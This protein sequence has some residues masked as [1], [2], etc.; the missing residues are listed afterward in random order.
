[1]GITIELGFAYLDLPDG[2][3]AGI[4]DV[5]GHERFVRNMLAGA[6]SI[7]L[8]ILVVAADEGIM[9]QTRE[10]L[11][12]LGLL[13][14]RHGLVA[15][16]KA[17]L[18]DEDWLAMV[19]LDIEDEL[20]GTF[21]ANAPIMPVSAY[22]GS[23]IEELRRTIFAMLS[24]SPA[25]QTGIPFRL[26]IDRVFTMDGFGTVVTGT[27][28]E[29]TLAVGDD[30]AVFP[31][32]LTTR[33][34][35]I[36]VHDAQVEQAVAGQRVAVNLAGLKVSDIG[37][38]DWAAAPASMENS[39]LLDVVLEV[40]KDCPRE[41]K[42][43][44][45]LHLHHGTQDVLC[46][47]M[48]MDVDKLTAGQRAYG[49]LR[50]AQPL[51]AKPQD[52]FVLRFYSPTETIGGGVILDPAPRRAKRHD[53]EN[54]QRLVLKENG[55]LKERVQV[56]F[57]ENSV[58]FPAPADLQ[59][60]YFYGDADFDAVL[61]ELLEEGTLVA[62]GDG[63]LYI[64]FLKEL[65]RKAQETLD[66]Y[67]KTNPLHG[68]MAL[69]ELCGKLLPRWRQDAAEYAVE[70]LAKL[71]FVKQGGQTVAHA[72]FAMAATDAHN[73]IRDKVLATYTQAGFATPAFDDVAADFAK[74]KR[75]FGQVFEAL[76][77][78]GQLVALTPQIH[79]TD[80]NYRK[81]L[82]LFA[83]LANGGEVTLGDFRDAINASRKYAL[84]FLEYFDKKA[85]T[86]KVGEGR[87]LAKPMD[88]V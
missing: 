16:N 79:V 68:G 2:Q 45:R 51:A 82:G 10:H 28:V 43:N 48:L 70:Q 71:G 38:G 17:D 56:I 81:A 74:E 66:K 64:S 23:G 21:L 39:R 18:V 24:Q 13:G 86:K 83:D 46:T 6:G 49:Q 59:R 65:G 40:N 32:G 26:P 27:L 78:G 67:H 30:V 20:A 84:A 88:F 69:R 77:K 3:R 50:L 5:P 75:A 55:T 19:T 25:K 22:T 36:Q 72:N 1:R 4:V 76:V 31:A 85:I 9:P 80:E 15:L 7:D 54:V 62:T 52:R 34:R 33:A 63:V 73:K 57:A 41:I 87:V 44:S 12:I 60:R 47:L 35:R 53:A 29:G 37:K 14:I 61:A 58:D 42:H 11:A 8:A